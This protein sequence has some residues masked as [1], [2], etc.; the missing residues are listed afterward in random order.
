VE[1]NLKS[2]T[3]APRK[4]DGSPRTACGR[5]QAAVLLE[6]CPAR[7]IAQGNRQ[8]TEP[9][10]KQE[11]VFGIRIGPAPVRQRPLQGQAVAVQFPI[12]VRMGDCLCAAQDEKNSITDG[13]GRSCRP[14]GDDGQRKQQRDKAGNCPCRLICLPVGGHVRPRC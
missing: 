3:V 13:S 6:K 12:D 14:V 7:Q 9:P 11:R 5:R 4:G 2:K 10:S 8:N 1:N